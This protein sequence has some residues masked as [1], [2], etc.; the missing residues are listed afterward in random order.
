MGVFV[1][2]VVVACVSSTDVSYMHRYGYG[3]EYGNEVRVHDDAD[4]DDRGLKRR[5]NGDEEA[6]HYFCV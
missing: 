2:F 5:R 6:T 1:G 4:D 3:Y